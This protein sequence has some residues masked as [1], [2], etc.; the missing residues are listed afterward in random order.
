MA[1]LAFERLADPPELDP[2]L[3]QPLEL[4]GSFFVRFILN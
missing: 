4:I 1:E 3:G 2:G